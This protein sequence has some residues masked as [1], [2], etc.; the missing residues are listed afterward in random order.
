MVLLGGNYGTLLIIETLRATTTS[1]IRC[2]QKASASMRLRR[3]CYLAFGEGREGGISSHH[4]LLL[5]VPAIISVVLA[6]N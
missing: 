1:I 6:V 3:V 4:D 2:L 5:A